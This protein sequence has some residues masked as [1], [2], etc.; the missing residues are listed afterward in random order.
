LGSGRVFQLQ[1][2]EWGYWEVE[3]DNVSPGE[4]YRFLLD[5]DRR[6][7]DPC[8]HFQPEG[9]FGP[10][11]I[12]DHSSY[13]WTDQQWEATP[14][15]E[16]VIYE[17]HIGTFT[18]SGTFEEAVRYLD[19]LLY[20]GVSTV[21]LMPVAQFT[22][23]RG[24]GY[25]GVF[26][27]AP[28]DSYGGPQGLKRFINACHM[29]GISVILDVVY[30]HFGPEG[31][32]VG[33]FAPYF[34]DRYKTPWGNAINFDMAESNEVRNFFIQNAIHWLKHYHVDGLRL[35]AVHSIYDLGAKHFL[36]ELKEAV[37]ATG[38][39]FRSP[40][41]LIAECDLNDSRII[42]RCTEGGHGLDAQWSDDFH[43]S[44]HAMLT[45]EKQ[46]YYMDF[47]SVDDLSTVMA[48]GYLY[49]GQYSSFRRKNH[50]NLSADLPGERFVFFVQ[51][52]DQVGNRMLGE[53]LSSLVCFDALKLSAGL[54][55]SLP[56]VPLIFMGEEYGETRPFLYFV[57][58]LDPDLC[59]SI[60]EGRKEEFSHFNWTGEPPDPSDMDTF[61]AS[62][63]DWG[64][65]RDG[66]GAVLLSYY[67]T[68]LKLKKRLGCLCRPSKER[69]QITR[70][71]RNI[72]VIVRWDEKGSVLALANTCSQQ[73]SI[74]VSLPGRW[75][76][77]ID[78]SKERWLGAGTALPVSIRTNDHITMNGYQFAMFSGRDE[79]AR[80][81][82]LQP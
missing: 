77:L 69:T 30:N 2:D 62:K 1:Q 19:D 35:D 68:L 67:R 61:L 52:H 22:G 16:M 66:S 56:Y 5:N 44:L 79:D 64:K 54:L 72:V 7:A 48:E 75:R 12:V 21:E 11:A 3:A 73:T 49:Q 18:P 25:D 57:D 9:V 60:R 15:P 34:S 26:L 29:K 55:F 81:K 51:N 14:L 76:K 41:L 50:G 80:R 59:E 63:L 38:H 8:S 17:L 46:G 36:K 43:H 37:N 65:R 20:L 53:R 23:K 78:S 32:Y 27:F 40:P 10:S 28:Q 45:G 33:E 4:T 6:R 47:G 58:C 31:S 24:W 13:P 42:R 74:R 70:W 71:G 39:G 82:V